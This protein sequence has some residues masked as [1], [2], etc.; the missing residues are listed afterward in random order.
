VAT[1]GFVMEKL[2]EGRWRVSGTMRLDDFRREHSDLA[3]VPGV[4][5]MGGLLMKLLDVVPSAGES[6]TYRGLKLTAQVVDERRVK[7][8]FVEATK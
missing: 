5:T 2:G 4:E 1:D 6:A 3:D 8:L 7:E